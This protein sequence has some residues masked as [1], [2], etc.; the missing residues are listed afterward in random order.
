[1]NA[2]FDRAISSFQLYALAAAYEL[3][4]ERGDLVAI[5]R[6]E[7][8]LREFDVHY[9]ASAALEGLIPSRALV[10]AW[11][12]AFDS[13]YEIL[14]PSGPHQT[15]AGR[16]AL[17]WAEIALYAG[18]AGLRDAAADALQRFDDAFGR[19]EDAT[20]HAVRGAILARLA[21]ELAGRPAPQRVVVTPAGR[22]GTLARAVD[23]VVAQRRGEAGATTLLGALEDLGRDEL[24]GMA[25]LFAAL[26]G[27]GS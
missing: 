4:V 18:A 14:A 13:A 23:A 20:D 5:E 10:E 22:L 7:R 16:E 27:R 17:R 1:V 21:A 26:P 15:P 24:A 25:K 9:G 3:Q 19:D 12:G 11:R 8:D 6:L 2:R